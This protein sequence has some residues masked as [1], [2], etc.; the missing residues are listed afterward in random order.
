MRRINPLAVSTTIRRSAVAVLAA[1]ALL[2]G[3]LT[4]AAAPA[5]AQAPA[6]PSVSLSTEGAFGGSFFSPAGP[7]TWATRPGAQ[8]ELNAMS[9]VYANNASPS[10]AG[11]D[12]VV[13]H[14]YFGPTIKRVGAWVVNYSLTV[15]P[16]VGENVYTAQLVPTGAPCGTQVVASSVLGLIGVRSCPPL[17]SPKAGV[18]VVFND[19]LLELDSVCTPTPGPTEIVVTD[20]GAGGQEHAEVI[21]VLDIPLPTYYRTYLPYWG[22]GLY[23]VTVLTGAHVDAFS[24]VHAGGQVS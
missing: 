3:G 6:R 5:Y 4:S 12:L 11:L 19:L 17:G 16:A 24:V 20:A 18:T 22:R 2:L 9:N 13:C 10:P 1:G 14:G 23:S 7:H 8:V 21:P 15:R